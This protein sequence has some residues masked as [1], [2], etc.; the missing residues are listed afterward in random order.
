M[1]FV[2]IFL[3][4]GLGS[5]ARYGL[6][7]LCAAAPIAAIPLGTLVANLAGSALIGFFFA[8]F[9][10]VALPA[11]FRFFVTVG[12]LGGFTTFSTYMLET[13]LMAGK[14]EY[15]SALLNF[16]LHN[17]LGFTAVAAGIFAFNLL[18]NGRPS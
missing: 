14:K 2:S 12:F 18:R 9:Q 4:G 6:A 15:A 3:G 11:A 10:D 17:V 1:T 7:R 13:W 5:L 16:A 8:L